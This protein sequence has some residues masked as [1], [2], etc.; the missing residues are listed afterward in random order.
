M[1]FV[2][3]DEYRVC[4]KFLSSKNLRRVNNS[5]DSTT[6]DWYADGYTDGQWFVREQWTSDGLNLYIVTKV[7]WEEKAPYK[8]HAYMCSAIRGAWQLADGIKHADTLYQDA[9]KHVQNFIKEKK[10]KEI[11]ECAEGYAL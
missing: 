1:N 8:V 10:V 2:S 6:F 4:K 11:T 9:M 7:K 5:N 3:I